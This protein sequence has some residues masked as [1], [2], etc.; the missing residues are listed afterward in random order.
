MSVFEHCCHIGWVVLEL[1]RQGQIIPHAAIKPM[2]AAIVAAMHDVGKWSPGFQN[3]CPAW[4]EREGL[5][6]VAKRYDWEA[7]RGTRHEKHSQDSIQLLF[8]SRGFKQSEA[9]AWAMVAGAHHGKMHSSEKY[10]RGDL[11]LLI[12]E[13]HNQRHQIITAIE[14]EFGYKISDIGIQKTDAVIPWLMGLTSVADW[15]GSDEIH[16]PVDKGLDEKEGKKSAKLAVKSIGFHKPQIKKNLQFKEIFGFCAN[17]MQKKALSVITRPGIYVIEAPMGLGKTEAALACAYELLQSGL[18]SGLYFALP[19]QLTS[20]RIHLRVSDFVKKITRNFDNTRLTHANAWLEDTYY[21]PRPVQTLIHQ[22]SD[23]AVASRDWFASAKRALLANFGVGTIDQ[24]LMSVVAVKHF[25]VRRFALAGKVVIIDEVH[26]YDHFTGTLVNCLCRELQKLGCT[27]IILSATLLP[28]VRNMLIDVQ[29]KEIQDD[30][31]PLISGKSSAGCLIAP[32]RSKPTP[33]PAVRRIFKK[34]GPLFSD[35]RAAAGQG[36]RVLWVCNTVNNAQEVFQEL[37]KQTNNFELGLL[38]SRFPH[39]MRQDQEEYW[40][41][42]LGKKDDSEGGCI[43]VSTQIVEQSVD[44]DADILISELAPMDMLL[45]RMGRLWRH[46]EDRPAPKRPVENPEIWIVEE[47]MTLVDLKQISSAKQLEKLLGV[48]AKV[49]LPYVLLKTYEA[50][51]RFDSISLADEN[52]NSDIRELLRLTYLNDQD[53][54]E[55]WNSLADDMKGIEYAEKQLALSNTRLFSR[56]ALADE[57]GKQTRLN[58]IETILLIIAKYIQAD[59]II[60]L[61]KDKIALK[62][63]KFNIC[64]ARSIHKNMIRVHAWPYEQTDLHSALPF[65]LKGKHCLALLTQNNELE[66]EGLKAGVTISWSKTL[67]IV[68]TYTK[69]GS[70]ESCD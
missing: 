6:L 1:I 8:Q 59:K 41:E 64:H 4:L 48:K 46:L 30:S 37:K 50:L 56:A 57:E 36:A 60:L 21:Q 62:P 65:Y 3:M 29:E 61:N 19:T 12:D 24:A 42:R 63:E 52:G 39:F 2:V 18:T 20:N 45:Q 17:D 26:S 40:M 68:Q 15:I 10:G 54:P 16:F 25:F 38:H 23:D 9:I 5:V 7:Q 67:G 69:G 53:D 28:E 49:Y 31:Y 32:Q 66:I 27:I 13:W 33:R 11:S 58:E 44:I 14:S 43:L 47:E 35:A 55:S 22:P 34:A 70:D 51:H